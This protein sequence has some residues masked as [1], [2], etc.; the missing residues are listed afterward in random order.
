MPSDL[1][2]LIKFKSA[3]AKLATSTQL[4]F[5]H[6]TGT[7]LH[8]GYPLI[9]ALKM[10]SWDAAL[11]P[12]AAIII[13]HLTRGDPIDVAFQNARFSQNIVHFLYFGRLHHDL[14]F[15]FQQCK[16]LLRLQKEYT[17][18]LKQAIRYPF[19]LFL[20]LTVGFTIIKQNILPNFQALFAGT[21]QQPFTFLFIQL[22]NGFIN[23][24]LI[25]LILITGLFLLWKMVKPKLVLEKRMKIYERIPLWKSYKQF[26]FTFLFSTHLSSL[27]AAGLTLRAS[28]GIIAKQEKYP[29]LAY[30]GC[31]ILTNLER[32]N[33][34]GQ[35]VHS[36]VLF[37]DE[38]TSLFH[39]TNDLEAL[40]QE[41]STLSQFLMEMLQ[42]RLTMLLQYIQP[43]FFM[44]I[45]VIIIVIYASIMLPLYEWMQ[46]I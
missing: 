26:L 31:L 13:E 24:L 28:L 38:M 4:L 40:S 3:S 16:D 34:L 11:K 25:L 5:F 19:I 44:M 21:N 18:K 30:Y 12:V 35:A 22:V 43:V 17:T 23:G 10:A 29:E 37:R 1:L 15:L 42:D 2:P 33:S 46:Q 39:H 7:L 32:G 36:C 20:F 6:R 8:K 41:L 9:E 27:L 45:A 14:P